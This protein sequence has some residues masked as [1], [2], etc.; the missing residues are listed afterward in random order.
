MDLRYLKN[1]VA[2][3]DHGSIS[4][5]AEHVFVAQPALSQQVAAL[6]GELGTQL[7]L[8][9]R[10][11]ISPTETGKVLYGHARTI[12]RQVE[13]IKA[14]VARPGA[15]EM[16]PVAVG[17]PTT[18]VSVLGLPLF[19]RVRALHPGI[20][21]H[22]VEAMSGYLGELLGFG[23]LDMAIQFNG[24]EVRG[25]N[26]Q[27]LLEED[28]YV[29]GD[30]SAIAPEDICSLSE[31][32][33]I[34][35][36]LPLHAQAL[37]MLVERSFAQNGL[38]LNVVANVDSTSTSIAIA[39]SGAACT[40]LP[41][42]SLASLEDKGSPRARKLVAPG[43]RRKVGLAWSTSLPHTK[44]AAAARLAI[45]EITKELVMSGRWAGAELTPNRPD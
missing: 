8:R 43:I 21:L 7:L 15:G 35:M 22:L 17:L 28:L 32:D 12:L 16:G 37:R 42:S 25:I 14:E 27:P 39:R 26:F 10:L 29:V 20:R 38:E 13:Q 41:L 40:I 33:G 30:S 3:V 6:E 31:L 2:I 45:V 4:K 18:M 36:V 11:G 1:F 44:A 9:S 23:R 34:P 5:A 19:E 24:A